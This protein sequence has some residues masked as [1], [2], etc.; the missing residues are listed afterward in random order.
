MMLKKL[1]MLVLSLLLLRTTSA[2]GDVASSVMPR[3]PRGEVKTF[4]G[5]FDGLFCRLFGI[6]NRCCTNRR[7]GYDAKG[8]PYG[9]YKGTLDSGGFLFYA[10]TNYTSKGTTST[11]PYFAC[12]NI[13]PIKPF[14]I[15]RGVIVWREIVDYGDINTCLPVNASLTK[16]NT[17]A[18]MNNFTRDDGFTAASGFMNRT[19]LPCRLL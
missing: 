9:S 1:V 13:K 2:A 4:G 15:D 3:T 8:N 19:C 10:E 11:Y 5:F 17:T 16:V 6:C 18:W 14:H 7:R 12:G